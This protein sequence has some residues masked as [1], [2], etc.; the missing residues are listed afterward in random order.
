M[1]KITMTVAA[2]LAT[3]AVSVSAAGITRDG[4][5]ITVVK[6]TPSASTEF[7]LPKGSYV[8]DEGTNKDLKI[9]VAVNGNAIVLSEGKFTLD[10]ESTCKVTATYVVEGTAHHT[11]EVMETTVKVAPDV[12]S[13]KEIKDKYTLELS[14]LYNKANGYETDETLQALALEASSLMGKISEFGL[15]E[16]IEYQDKGKLAELEASIIE[17]GDKIA[18]AQANYVAHNNATVAG[19]ELQVELE[20][21]K[22][23][24]DTK[25]AEVK[26]ADEAADVSGYTATY[27]GAKKLVDDFNANAE[28]AYKNQTAASDFSDDNIT[29]KKKEILDALTNAEK[30]IQSGTTNELSYANVKNTLTSAKNE[31]WDIV[32]D[33]YNHLL[34]KDGEGNLYSD[35]YTDALTELHKWYSAVGEVGESNEAAHEA[36]TANADT[37]AKYEKQI[38]E[39][40]SGMKAVLTTTKATVDKWRSYY[41]AAKADIAD[42]LQSYF[43]TQVISYTDNSANADAQTYFKSQMSAIQTEIDALTT[44]VENANKEH[45]LTAAT[46]PFG[47]MNYNDKKSAIIKLINE[48]SPKVVNAVAE[49][50]AN[51]AAVTS[52]KDVDKVYADVKSKADNAEDG[53][54]N[55]KGFLAK[56]KFAATETQIAGSIGKLTA[57][58]ESA[59]NK[60]KAEF[61][62]SLTNAVDFNNGLTAKLAEVRESID[63]YKSA[64][65]SAMSSYKTVYDQCAAFKTALDALKDASK[66]NSDVTIDGKVAGT[67]YATRIDELEASYNAIV[68]SLNAAYNKNNDAELVSALT[69]LAE[70]EEFKAVEGKVSAADALASEYKNNKNAWEK[71]VVIATKE[72]TL[73]RAKTLVAELKED[74]ATYIYDAKTYGKA[75]ISLT[76]EKSGF[77]TTLNGFESQISDAEKAE[78]SAETIS[79]LSKVNSNLEVLKTEVN[80]LNEKAANVKAEYAAETKAYDTLT[81]NIAELRAKVVNIKT[82]LEGK[83][84]SHRRNFDTEATSANNLLDALA[85]DIN[86][87]YVAETLRKDQQ[88]DKGYDNRMTSVETIVN[89]LHKL[90]ANEEAN[91][92]HQIAFEAEKNAAKVSSLIAKAKQDVSKVSTGDGLIHFNDVIASYEKEYSA[93]ESE[94][95]RYYGN[96]TTA[97]VEG[98]NYSNLTDTKKNMTA[99]HASLT[100]RLN[101]LVA[102]IKAVAGKAEANEVAFATLTKN[103][104]DVSETWKNVLKTISDAPTSSYHQTAISALND[105]KAELSAF[106]SALASDFGKGVAGDNQTSLQSKL[107]AISTTIGELAESWASQYDSAIT[108][109]NGVRYNDFNT[110]YKKLADTYK[111]YITIVTEM[112]KTS[113]ASKVTEDLVSL[114]GKDGIFSYAEK[115]RTLKTKADSEYNATVATVDVADLYDVNETNKATAVEYETTIIDMAEKYFKAVNDIAKT[116]Y[117]KDLANAKQ[118]YSETFD[119]MKSEIYATDDEAKNALKG[120]YDLISKASA[121]SGVDNMAVQY[122][123]TYKAQLSSDAVERLVSAAQLTAANLVW[124]DRTS[125]ATQKAAS[126]ANEIGGFKSPTNTDYAKKYAVLAANIKEASEAW[127]NIAEADK[128][129]KFSEAYT[130]LARFT[131]TYQTRSSVTHTS[132]YWAAYDDNESYKTNDTW[133]NKMLADV[134]GLQALL[135]EAETFAEELIVAREMDATIAERQSDIDHISSEADSYHDTYMS[136]ENTYNALKLSMDQIKDDILSVTSGVKREAMDKE[137]ARIVIVIGQLQLDYENATASKISDGTIDK[138]KDFFSACSEKIDNYSTKNQEILET[139]KKGVA[140]GSDADKFAAINNAKAAY[141]ELEK[142]IGTT[143][144]ELANLCAETAETSAKAQAALQ[145]SINKILST[146]ASLVKQLEDC[147][148]PVVEQYKS[149][150]DAMGEA[151]KPIQTKLDAAVADNTVLLYEELISANI[152]KV[153][154][155]YEGL[156]AKIAEMEAP[157]DVNDAK[158]S[159]LC[160]VMEGLTASL[161]AVYDKTADFMQATRDYGCTIDGKWVA[162]IQSVRDHDYSD[163]KTTIAS[164]QKEIDNLNAMG[165]GLTAS[166]TVD[167]AGIMKQI[168][169]YERKLS[170]DN[171]D[172]HIAVSLIGK[173]DVVKNKI[174]ANTYARNYTELLNDKVGSIE[175]EIDDIYDWN[176]KFGTRSDNVFEENGKFMTYYLDGDV[177]DAKDGFEAY[178]EYYEG[179]TPYLAIMSNITKAESAIDALN[180]DADKIVGDADGDGVVGV[181]DYTYIVNVIMESSLV[182]IPEEGTEAFELADANCDGKIDVA[183]A[184]AVVNAIL[185][186]NTSSTS[187][188]RAPRFAAGSSMSL[189]GEGSGYNQRI[190]INLNSGVAFAGGQIDLVLPEGMTVS[191]TSLSDRASGMELRSATL[192]SG[193]TRLLISS[194]ENNVIEGSE[195][196]VAYID[197][198]VDTNYKGQTIEMSSAVFADADGRKYSIG[199]AGEATGINTVS[200]TEYI[201]GKVYSVGGQVLDG[202]KKGI[203]IIH[204]VDGTLKKVLVK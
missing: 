119:K 150:V 69:K 204:N 87:S 95:T 126:E 28:T 45:S 200:A 181:N 23:I 38:A 12:A 111:G 120:V 51:N 60:S 11:T 92:A 96:V 59:Y 124:N 77:E 41:K 118:L 127:N 143:K 29:A 194:V 180:E 197:V 168:V 32:S 191:G 102:D 74:L 136:A 175:N 73:N 193:V 22:N 4:V 122:E 20:A 184:V 160:A 97:M 100:A 138:Y 1:S 109:D 64:M 183:D 101:T 26:A 6:D 129:T 56:G 27:E 171:A 16:Y 148:A 114:A 108:T 49:I 144:G 192:K 141:L 128:Y 57:D 54:Y 133:Y 66:E 71:N 33:M 91:D 98:T 130:V 14:I 147:H 174:A 178:A 8:I 104:N 94:Q 89:E 151:I 121:L 145:A 58:R 63:A 46:A 17:I 165:T 153:V 125:E 86:S 201:K 5:K 61:D 131:N 80:K 67:T 166:S 185:G 164:A 198:N 84:A 186:K 137:F 75:S 163:I 132:L 70:S 99:M 2:F 103:W 24:Y 135:D 123:N 188:R 115:I 149:D 142:N 65:T 82:V 76:E 90:A 30:A 203:N 199:L 179:T 79:L 18:K 44:S 13:L 31:Y 15:D 190:V 187:V 10:K 106:G 52:I 113:F 112:S 62:K 83:N 40:V 105:A 117:E 172:K 25:V 93:I 37:Q 182:E 34:Q 189:V 196:A 3:A 152:K 195:G 176:V 88:G 167:R 50:A 78:A 156:D 146:R 47:V 110:A 154:E 85:S 19:K 39:A 7:S 134:D 177:D 72:S 155:V 48:L 42:N 81:A 173:L 55:Y 116:E 21:L 107:D 36:G 162:D 53:T 161:D 140:T 68:N 169:G 170:Y 157:Y 35:T 202:L 139:L 158:Y 43:K 159:E 9:T